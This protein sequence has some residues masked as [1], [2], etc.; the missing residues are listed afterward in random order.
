MGEFLSG[1]EEGLRARGEDTPAPEA[2]DAA[3]LGVLEAL[4][5]DLDAYLD[6]ELVDDAPEEDSEEDDADDLSALLTLAEEEIRWLARSPETAFAEAERAGAPLLIPAWMRE[7]PAVAVAEPVRPAWAHAQ[8][9]SPPA[10]SRSLPW[11]QRASAAPARPNLQERPW[12]IPMWE[13]PP[14]TPHRGLDIVSG[15]LLGVAVV[16]AL[17][18][19][20][21]VVASVRL[22][23]VG[24]FRQVEV[25]ELRAEAQR[26]AL[27]DTQVPV[28]PAS[29]VAPPRPMEAREI[30]P[31][32]VGAIPSVPSSTRVGDI[33]SAIQAP[34]A[35]AP[36]AAAASL[37]TM[38]A[39]DALARQ[40]TL[41]VTSRVRRAEEA[42][43]EQEAPRS[44]Q[45]EA[46]APVQ[47]LT[48]EE[49]ATPEDSTLSSRDEAVVE[50]EAAE[51][52]LD[53]EFARELGFTE[54]AAPEASEP[55]AARTVYVPPELGEKE[56]LTADDIQQV[57]VANQPAVAECLH[58]HA[59]ESLL[60]K[61]GHFV[62]S[63]S[64]Q[65]GGET[66]D[67]AMDTPA[68][69]A[70]PV[71]SCIEGVVR[72]WKFPMHAVRMPAPIH[73][74]FVF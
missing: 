46:Q 49:E 11:S 44:A 55:T 67:V 8:V 63:W 38:E 13:G 15:V 58:Q 51:S 37:A 4:D 14:R 69:R 17:A 34:P 61:G 73:F 60:E 71:A 74:P 12:G 68:L 31:P 25:A 48:F 32:V 64:V 54:E 2:G 62:V 41:A 21:L 7:N 20:M 56:H 40:D 66:T 72:G 43:V 26:P 50:E 59:A 3:C 35:E 28:A 16:G 10:S 52:E 39:T 45:G 24:T 70:T 29:P 65:P 33:A 6:R 36:P 19:G 5:A 57:V 53:E 23:E 42:A 27:A 30:P 9:P 22:W 1:G 47:E 18:A